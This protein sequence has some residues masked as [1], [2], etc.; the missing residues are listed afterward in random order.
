[1]KLTR[2][3]WMGDSMCRQYQLGCRLNAIVR[4]CIRGCWRSRVGSLERTTKRDPNPK[5]EIAVAQLLRRLDRRQ[6]ERYGFAYAVLQLWPAARLA[7]GAHASHRANAR[8]TIGNA[9]NPMSS[10]AIA[11]HSAILALYRRSSSMACSQGQRGLSAHG[12]CSSV[13]DWLSIRR[14]PCKRDDAPTVQSAAAPP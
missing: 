5:A 13:Q 4:Q 11:C 1:M 10:A 9:T 6:I 2:W 3:H 8:A 12:K 7:F 14:A